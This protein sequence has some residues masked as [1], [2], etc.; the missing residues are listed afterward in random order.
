MICFCRANNVPWEMLLLYGNATAWRRS[1]APLQLVARDGRVLVWQHK[2]ERDGGS[3]PL[4]RS[5]PWEERSGGLNS[6][7]KDRDQAS[8]GRRMRSD[9]ARILRRLC[10]QRAARGPCFLTKLG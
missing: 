10:T 8:R 9:L 1:Q 4:S 3:Q 6:V 7:S 2:L 5:P